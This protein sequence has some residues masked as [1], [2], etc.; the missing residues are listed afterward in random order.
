[1]E[2]NFDPERLRPLEYICE[3]DPRSTMWVRFDRVAGTSRSV[4][5]ADHY[6][7][8]FAVALHAGV[9]EEI[10]LQFE[11]TRNV[12]LYAWFVYRFYPVAE[13]HSLACLELALRERLKEEIRTGKIE[14]R[15]KRPTLRALL[16]YAVAQGI[17]K[18]EGFQTWR[19]RGAINSRARTEMEKVHEMSEKN[20]TEIS[21]D[22]S[23]IQV[24]AEDL[25][26]DY[27]NMLVDLLPDLR[28]RYAHGSTNLHNLALL[29]IRIVC[30]I[31][32]QLYEAPTV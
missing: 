32:N 3:P 13:Q 25:N 26:W 12:Y 28:N 21:R 20:L 30:E 7:E 2:Q 16:K 14:S 31:I 6:E 29:T 19:R 23:D 17:V 1:M 27:A 10:L 9:P 22:E 24:T 11:T 5:L 15:Q 8:I 18:N 4:E